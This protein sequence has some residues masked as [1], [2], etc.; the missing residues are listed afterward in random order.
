MPLRVLNICTIT[1]DYHNLSILNI[2]TV[3]KD[4]YTIKKWHI[5]MTWI[6]IECC[7]IDWNWHGNNLCKNISSKQQF[8]LSIQAYAC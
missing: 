3:T 4:L 1:K 8:K 6:Y 2:C 7:E 5:L